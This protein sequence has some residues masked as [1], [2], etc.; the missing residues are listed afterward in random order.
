MTNKQRVHAVLEGRPVDRFPVT[1]IYHQLY[2]QD[3]F[4][5]LTGLPSWRVWEWLGSSPERYVE[6]F[7]V[8]QKKTPFELL[9]PHGAPSRAWRDR[10]DFV[11]KDG[12]GWRHNRETEEWARLAIDRASGHATDSHANETQHVFNQDDV[13]KRVALTTAETMIAEGRN[14][15][16][17]AVIERY[18]RDEFV[19]TGGVIGTLYQCHRH[20]GLTNLFAMVIEQPDL[21]EY[22]SACILEQNIETIRRYA[23]AGG[24]AVFI[25][26]ACTTRDMIS[27]QHYERFS[28]PYMKPMVDEIHRHGMKAILIYF[29]G[30]ADRLAQIVSLG[31]DGLLFEAS[32]KGYVNDVARIATDIGD[33]VTVFGNL[34]PVGILQQGTDLA[35][36]REVERQIEAGRRGRGFV[37][38]PSSPITPSTPLTRVQRF[39]E[40]ATKA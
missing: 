6:L 21:I 17:E 4:S 12:H 36:A 26:D 23:A 22:L 7:S 30:I 10:M 38:S 28:L 15:Y 39:I 5:E 33:R 37:L 40:L 13:R 19:I 14:D 27:V 34:D 35:L 25:D 29:G 1:S 24:D 2:R 9:Q 32:M 31:A 11:E 8:M 3:H 16:A 20:V 18:G